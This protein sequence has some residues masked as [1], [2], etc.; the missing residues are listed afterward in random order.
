MSVHVCVSFTPF[1]DVLPVHTNTCLCVQALMLKNKLCWTPSGLMVSN[2]KHSILC[3]AGNRDTDA[4]CKRSVMGG[5]SELCP[6]LPCPSCSLCQLQLPRQAAVGRVHLRK[7]CCMGPLLT[8]KQTLHQPALLQQCF[9]FKYVS[10]FIFLF[11]FLLHL[12]HLAGCA[13]VTHY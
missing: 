3:K 9:F 2:T 12:A 13:V 7:P 8:P 4:S 1:M 10:L 6:I 11:P 5:G